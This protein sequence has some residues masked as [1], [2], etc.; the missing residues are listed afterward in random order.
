MFY[1]KQ[2][3]KMDISFS[4]KIFILPHA[5]FPNQE[6]DITEASKGNSNRR[7]CIFNLWNNLWLCTPY[8]STQDYIGVVDKQNTATVVLEHKGEIVAYAKQLNNKN[9]LPKMATR[10]KKRYSG[11]TECS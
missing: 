3:G 11:T 10:K 5:L 4:V 8:K 2:S 6:K 9:E 7:L 1:N